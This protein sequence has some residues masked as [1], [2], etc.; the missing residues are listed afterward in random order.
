MA[1]GVVQTNEGSIRAAE[2]YILV[3][4]VNETP[5]GIL[6]IGKEDVC[7][8]ICVSIGEGVSEFHEGDLI[9][10]TH[11]HELEPGVVGIYWENC[12]AYNSFHEDVD[13]NPLP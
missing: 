4:P 5:S 3:K 13:D 12:I 11:G 1:V 6:I 2:G 10:Y 7:K 8:G 9:Y